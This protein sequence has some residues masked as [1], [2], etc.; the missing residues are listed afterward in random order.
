MLLNSKLSVLEVLIVSD[1]NC[2]KEAA[3]SF[4]EI[5]NI[6]SKSLRVVDISKNFFNQ[7][8]K[9]ILGNLKECANL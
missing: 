6:N 2:P 3:K 8:T 7:N 5:I 1:C 4:A 9:F